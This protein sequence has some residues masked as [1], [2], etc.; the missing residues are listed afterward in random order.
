MTVRTEIEAAKA[1][2]ISFAT[3]EALKPL[4]VAIKIAIQDGTDVA[5]IMS[6]IL[7]EDTLLLTAG[8][9]FDAILQDALRLKE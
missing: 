3:K 7:A 2:G 9:D 8:K 1:A 6:E 5:R 4:P